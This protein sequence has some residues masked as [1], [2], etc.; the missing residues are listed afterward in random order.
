MSANS[1]LGV[2][3]RELLAFGAYGLTGAALSSLVAGSADAKSPQPHFEPKAKRVIHICLMGGMSHLDSFDYSPELEKLHGKELQYEERP[4][5]FFN[6]IGLIRKNDWAFK[7]RGDSGLWVSDLFPHLATVADELTVIKSM[8]GD[9]ANHTPA[10][11]QQNTG[12]QLNGFPVMGSWISYG[13]GA[14]TEDLPTYVVLPDA[15][16]YPAG[17]TINW[18]NGFLPSVH[19]GVAFNSQGTPIPDLFPPAAIAPGTDVASRKLLDQM[20]QN[21]LTRNG[22]EDALLARIRSHELAARMQLTVPEVAGLGSETAATK[23]M[24]GLNREPTA[25]FGKNCLLSRRLLEKG[26]RFVQIIS[27]GSFGSPRINWDGHED[28]VKNHNRE[29]MRID[30]PVAALIKDLKQRSMLDDTLILFTTEFGR[31]PYTQAGDGVLGKGRD[32]NM[33]GFSVFMAGAGLKRGFAYGE[34]DEIGWKS[35]QD[36]AHWYD[37]H[38]TV[39]HLLGMDHERLTFYHNG[40]ERRLTNVHGNVINGVLA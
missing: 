14:E 30:Q 33:Y 3:R 32:H 34:T 39:L 38:A 2:S 21:D 16:G 25:D 23:E 35:V 1:K 8:V 27:G 11:F 6:R 12:F 7:Q 26:V 18:S 40:I 10:T 4:A 36:P 37:F 5:T 19:Q 20:N 29:A 31:T 9:S 28:M 24:Y 22:A 13:L 17:G 15:R